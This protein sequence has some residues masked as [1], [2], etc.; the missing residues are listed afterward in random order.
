MNSPDPHS[1][2]SEPRSPALGAGDRPEAKAGPVYKRP[3]GVGILVI[4]LL[5]I[6]GAGMYWL[7]ARHYESTDD[8]FI[9]AHITH[10]APRVAGRVRQVLVDDNQSVEAGALLIEIDPADYQ[11]KRDQAVAAN[12]EAESR[13]H[14]ASARQT[15]ATTSLQQAQAE[16]AA[17]EANATNAATD[18][19]RIQRLR[20]QGVASQQEFD[21]ANTA[22][23]DT[24]ARLA[25]AR[26]QVATNEAQVVLAAKQIQTATAVV[27]SA[28][29]A[30]EQANLQLSYTQGRAAEAGRVTHK[31]VA[32]G[33]YV[34]IGQDLMAMVPRDLWVTAN[35]K[36]TQLADM[37]PGQPVEITV[38]AYPGKTFAGHVD[39][40]QAGSGARFSLLPPENATGNYVKVVQRVP[41]KIVF[42]DPPGGG[43]PYLLGPGMSVVPWVKVR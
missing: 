25:A 4:V 18:L 16:T 22:A 15:A 3:L 9:D 36:E 29:A 1:A 2:A 33:D 31:S 8:A 39:S 40:V 14:E 20:A 21:N 27:Q 28:T 23:K 7:H 10:V 24:A 26:Q 17:A 43:S 11:V 30:L 34:Q 32:V 6:G 12:A 19:A 35:F 42:D 41:V 5:C 37:R 38:D 13:L